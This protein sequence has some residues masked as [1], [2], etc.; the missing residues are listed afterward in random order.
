MNFPGQKFFP[1]AVITAVLCAAGV[2]TASGQNHTTP[3]P[4]VLM[5]TTKGTMAIRV[6]SRMAPTTARNFLDLVRRGYY[7][8][9]TFHR[10]E[11][12]CIQGGCPIGDGTG[13]YCEPETGRPRFIPLEINRNLSH[14][15]AGVVAM[16]RSTNPNSAS[17]QFYILKS[18]MRQLDGQY[19]IFG[20]VVEGL[21]TIYGINIG[22]RIIHA[23]IVNQADQG[24]G[25]GGEE[26]SAAGSGNS[27]NNNTP[28]SGTSGQSGF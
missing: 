6:F 22:D 9:K 4:V 15:A 28:T 11:R 26:N 2:T 3:D 8:G 25:S 24:N 27:S 13:S 20:G 19:A 1:A 14:S 23:E 16:A 12:W 10:V 18:P 7:D 21:N 5:K 17:C